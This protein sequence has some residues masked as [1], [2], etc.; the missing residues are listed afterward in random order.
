MVGRGRGRGGS[1][2]G[3][4]SVRPDVSSQL[5]VKALPAS[6][7]QKFEFQA[8]KKGWEYVYNYEGMDAKMIEQRKRRIELK[9]MFEKMVLAEQADKQHPFAEN[10]AD[11]VKQAFHPFAAPLNPEEEHPPTYSTTDQ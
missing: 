9:R 11:K 2:T 10:Q 7:E 4:N 1:T 3:G 8:E 6:I 5:N